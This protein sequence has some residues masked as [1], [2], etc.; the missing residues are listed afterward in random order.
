[1]SEHLVGRRRH[2][3]GSPTTPRTPTELPSDHTASSGFYGVPGHQSRST[4]NHIRSAVLPDQ[5]NAPRTHRSSTRQPARI[6]DDDNDSDYGSPYEYES[7]DEDELEAAKPRNISRLIGVDLEQ[8]RRQAED[9]IRQGGWKADVA[10]M[11][12]EWTEAKAWNDEDAK[13]HSLRAFVRDVD[14][15]GELCSDMKTIRGFLDDHIH[16]FIAFHAMQ[17][18]FKVPPY[19]VHKASQRRRDRRLKYPWLRSFIREYQGAPSGTHESL[20]QVYK[21]HVDEHHHSDRPPQ[22]TAPDFGGSIHV[23]VPT[24]PTTAALD[25]AFAHEISDPHPDRRQMTLENN[26]HSRKRRH[27]IFD[28]HLDLRSNGMMKRVRTLATED[29][30]IGVQEPDYEANTGDA[31]VE[32]LGGTG[33]TG[34]ADNG[35]EVMHTARRTLKVIFHGTEDDDD[36]ESE[37]VQVYVPRTAKGVTINLL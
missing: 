3:F 29:D 24:A 7:P 30:F 16:K 13:N 35:A 23:A 11:A 37:H 27:R 17:K 9:R 32:G 12:I 14:G 34:G 22:P 25:A 26:R 33:A 15:V 5:H 10:E 31:G 36:E 8:R 2:I 20:V 21:D 28:N 19:L 18:E 1:M 6:T 4:A